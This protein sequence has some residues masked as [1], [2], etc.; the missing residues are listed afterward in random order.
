MAKFEQSDLFINRDNRTGVS[1]YSGDALSDVRD[2]P[3]YMLEI[4]EFSN[5]HEASVFIA[6]IETAGAGNTLVYD[7]NIGSTSSNKVVIVGRMDQEV[8]ID[9]PFHDRV[10][11]KGVARINADAEA[12][13]RYHEK[14]SEE[15][16]IQSERERAELSRVMESIGVATER[17]IQWGSGWARVDK[18]KECVS[19]DWKD[20][21]GPF[22]VS[23]DIHEIGQGF[24]D[25]RSQMAAMAVQYGCV[26]NDVWELSFK[27]PIQ[28]AD[29]LRAAIAVVR[30][31]V[32]DLHEERSR[33]YR[34][35]FVSKTKM[36]AKWARMI[37][38]GRD[39]G[40]RTWIVRRMERAAVGGDEI[41]RTD[42]HTL[43]SVGWLERGGVGLI[44]TASGLEAAE[45]KLG[46]SKTPQNN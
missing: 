21:S 22:E 37:L 28:D 9:T 32:Q 30:G 1:V 26:I 11:T 43:L 45:E 19:I 5:D 12:M 4:W 42:I 44:P 20:T 41:G 38:A 17:A 40:I 25:I 18:G 29:A 16:R 36:S 33:I 8:G 15:R 34:A 10:V 6:G 46:K 27:D 24:I 13:K 14:S 39:E 7:R 31:L 35:D 23:V 2:L 3:P